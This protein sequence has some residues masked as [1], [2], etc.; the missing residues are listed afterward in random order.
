MDARP[1]CPKRQSV[2]ARY[3]LLEPAPYPKEKPFGELKQYESRKQ[4]WRDYVKIPE[5][6]P[7]PPFPEGKSRQL[8]F[9]P[10][11]NKATAPAAV[12]AN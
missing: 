11:N 7:I 5:A 1:G 2:E 3:I 12:A 10:N 9:G 6:G 8:L 4:P